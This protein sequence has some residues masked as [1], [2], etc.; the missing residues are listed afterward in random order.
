MPL[1]PSPLLKRGT[2]VTATS[3]VSLSTTQGVATVKPAN[4]QVEPPKN[5]DWGKPTTAVEAKP[6]A[7]VRSNGSKVVL[8]FM[9]KDNRPTDGDNML[10]KS[11]GGDQID[12]RIDSI[13]APEVAH[14]KYGKKG[15]PYGEESKRTLEDLVRNKE[16]SVRVLNGTDKYNRP[17][18][19]IEVEGQ[20]VG[21]LMA[22][23]GA[24]WAYRNFGVPTSQAAAD[25]E[26]SAKKNRQGLWANDDARNPREFK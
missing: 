21:V 7:Q 16:V 13:D 20:D 22:Q 19:Q 26:A 8:T 5:V 2:P 24:A 23:Q 6:S 17:V 9:S 25:A 10:V 15:Q 1:A 3:S 14:Q 18:C 12:C 11:P 4:Q